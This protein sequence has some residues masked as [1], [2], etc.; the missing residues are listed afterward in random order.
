M[1]TLMSAKDAAQVILQLARNNQVHAIEAMIDARDYLIEQGERPHS[2]RR[3]AETWRE[4]RR[5]A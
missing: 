1:S 5:T 3:K 2:N 4:K